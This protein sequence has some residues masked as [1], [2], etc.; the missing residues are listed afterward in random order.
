MVVKA[1]LPFVPAQVVGLVAVPAV[2]VGAVGSVKTFEVATEPVQPTL[3]IEKG[4]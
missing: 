2:S 4:V 1:M 3:V